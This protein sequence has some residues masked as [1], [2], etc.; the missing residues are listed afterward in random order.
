MA[1]MRDRAQELTLNNERL[2]IVLANLQLLLQLHERHLRMALRQLHERQQPH[3]LQ[4]LLMHQA[5]RRHK[6]LVIVIKRHIRGQLLGHENRQQIMDQFTLQKA[7]RLQRQ[8]R[9]QQECV[10]IGQRRCNAF[11]RILTRHRRILS[12]VS[13]EQLDHHLRGELRVGVLQHVVQQ[14]VQLLHL[15]TRRRTLGELALQLIDGAEHL[16]DLIALLR[17][18][19]QM[20]VDVIAQRRRLLQIVEQAPQRL[21]AHLRQGRLFGLDEFLAEGE[22]DVLAPVEIH[23]DHDRDDAVEDAVDVAGFAVLE[24]DIADADDFVQIVF[25]AFGGLLGGD[26]GAQALEVFAEFLGL[27]R[28]VYGR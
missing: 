1:E 10:R 8:Q 24:A 9:I 22:N 6:L 27:V 5:L 18:L 2:H 11:H 3:L 7:H 28:V 14:P 25:D 26:F 23:R 21:Q 13:A 20:V 15:L 19:H 17:H 16:A 12:R 4:I